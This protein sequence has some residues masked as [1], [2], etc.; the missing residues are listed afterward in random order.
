MNGNIAWVSPP[1][2]GSVGDSTIFKRQL[3]NHVPDGYSV[4]V[5]SAYGIEDNKVAPATEFDSEQVRAFKKRALARHET[6]NKRIKDFG[7][8]SIRFRHSLEFHSVCFHSSS[9]VCQYNIEEGE[10]LFLL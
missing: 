2:R 3:R 7:A 10:P 5:D 9:V 8:T 4:I 6:A 1:Y